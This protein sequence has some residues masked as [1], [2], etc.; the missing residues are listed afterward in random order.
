[1]NL[2][3]IYTIVTLC[4]LGA[5]AAV[6]LYFVAQKFKV[7][8]D[9]RIDEVES[10]LPGANCGGCG[11]AGCRAFADAMVKNE[12][13]SALYCPVGGAKTMEAVAGFLGKTA[14]EKAPEVAVLRCNGSCENRPATTIYN[15]A[16]SC[17]I[18]AATYAGE[19][20]CNY[21]CLSQGDCAVS[22]SFGAISMNPKTLLPEIDE[23]KC[24]ACGSCVKA[25]PK[26]IIELRGKGIKSRRVYVA[27]ASKDRGVVSKKAC[28]VSCIGC[29]KCAKVC[30]FEAIK[31]ENNLAYIDGVKCKLCRKC[32]PEC[33][34]G[35]IA[36]VNFPLLRVA[37]QVE[38]AQN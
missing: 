36:E 17:A 33:P 7:Y 4:S 5:L 10:M 13:I 38:N 28:A 21:G 2:T 34:T 1:M 18:L 11:F 31:I 27:C 3:L 19:T 22:C 16:K 23:A 6:V 15:G 32:A 37:V 25:C 30:A 29:T 26:A 24:T 8:E 35:A 9:P 20:A 14:P 12:D